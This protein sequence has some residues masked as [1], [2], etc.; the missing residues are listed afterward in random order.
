M[1]GIVGFI[2]DEPAA[3]VVLKALIKLEYRGYD[4][5]GMVSVCDGKLH[6]RKDAGRITDVQRKHRL[7]RL[8]GNIAVGHVRWA[9]HGRADRINAHPH[10]DCKKQIAV[11]H[12]GIIENYQ[13]L[14]AALV[15]KHRFASEVDTEVICHL[16]EDYMEAGASLEKALLKAIG[17]LRGSYALVVVSS[18]EPE[19]IVATSKDSP[20]I[21]GLD[22]GKYFVASDALSFLDRTNEVVFLE[23]G[24]LVSLTKDGATFLNREGEEIGK[25][26]QRVDWQWEEASKK[27]YDFFMLKEI[28]EQPQ[29]MRRAL[30]QDRELIME[31]AKE[32]SEARQ[33]VITACGT[34]RHVALLASH[35]FSRLAGK[36]CAVVTASEFQYF[37][38]SISEDTLV[39][40]VSQSGE[41]ADVIEGV[42]RA[43]AKGARVF[44]IVNVIGSLLTRISDRV[45]YLNCGPEIGVAA[46]KSFVNQ[47]A[48]FY[49]LAFALVG[50][51]EEGIEKLEQVARQI[52]D[53]LDDEKLRKLARRMKN[54]NDFYYIAK[55]LN[56]AIAAEGALKLKEISYIHAECMPAGEL[57]HGTLAL[58][59]EG[60]PVV[61][62]C[63]KDD[64]FYET[65]NNVMEIKARGGFVIGVSDENN[66]IYDH[67][68]RIPKME[69]I[70]Y[71]LV[72][73]MP[74]QLLAYHLAAARGKDPDRPRHLAKSVTVK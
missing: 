24:E 53:N 18:R 71:P 73:I 27:G 5:A 66:E 63:P 33:V 21:V 14:R 65:L 49:M 70:F 22:E 32:I 72:A 51:L 74:L 55:G 67:W 47:S 8:P 62:I 25:R 23:E 10:F 69:E 9:T 57:K 44:S 35:L 59:E 30:I 17:E 46:T 20:L 3:P 37:S 52:E 68:I 19:K 13:E 39:I 42:K 6:F 48:I 50:K 41:T 56:L 36:L 58:I 38:D 54:K 40:A 60:T 64:T 31:F 43:K 45:I 7:D 28:M 34:S 15:G 16:I 1:C 12:N 11:V 26:S 2:G 4:S 29:V 61:A